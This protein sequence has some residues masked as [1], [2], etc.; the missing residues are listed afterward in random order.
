MNAAK[1]CREIAINF[2]IEHQC[3]QCGAPAILE[4]TDRL[5]ACEFCRVNSYLITDDFFR[6]VLPH[7]ADENKE[8]FYFPYWRFKGMLFFCGPTEIKDRFVDISQQAI[9]SQYFPFSAG[10]RSQAMKIR[11]VT[12]D[13]DGRFL[14]PRLKYQKIFGSFEQRFGKSLPRPIIHQA[15]IGETL[16]LIY[17][18]FYVKDKLYDAVLDK[19]VSSVLPEEFNL[20]EF[21]DTDPR[22]HIRFVSTLCPNCGWDLEGERDALVLRCK[23]CNSAW[24]PVGNKLKQMKFAHVASRG[25]DTT[26]LPFWRIR[27]EFSG[28]NLNSYADL[29]KIANL[30]K[31]VQ[32]HWHDIAFRFWIPAFK[33]RPR[34]FLRLAS[35]FTV[36]QP[37]DE[38]IPQL[39][40]GKVHPGNLPVEEAIESLKLTLA[41]FM[42]PR[43]TLS[44]KLPEIKVNAKRFTLIY[45][46]FNEEHHEYIQPDYQIAI[47]KNV[48]T[49]SKNL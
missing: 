11:F 34:I 49:L 8:I 6:Y 3:P 4:E 25:M 1:S 46:P 43:K 37:Q 38:L 15:H 29:V 32:S 30:P 41:D 28:L 12:P 44:E 7:A 2:R 9:D 23:N 48:M 26:Y 21:A 33:V 24:Y 17:S 36:V 5:F 16:S 35:Q 31:A 19:P 42:K 20:D 22:G 18:P 10:L 39:P 45:L 40:D 27:A 47:N 14:K 13:T